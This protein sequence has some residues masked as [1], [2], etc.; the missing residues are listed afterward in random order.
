MALP[1]MSSPAVDA[2]DAALDEMLAE[3]QRDNAFADALRELF[4]RYSRPAEV[5]HMTAIARGAALRKA[6]SGGYRTYSSGG[7][8]LRELAS[9]WRVPPDQVIAIHMLI[10]PER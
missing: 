3:R 6:R 5:S 2:I 7:M 10:Y 1:H 8:L 4:Y 9:N